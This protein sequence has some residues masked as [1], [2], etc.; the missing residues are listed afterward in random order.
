[1]SEQT[2]ETVTP[3]TLL[4]AVDVRR[5]QNCRLVVISCTRLPET[6]QLTY[7]FDQAGQFG[8]VRLELPV[9]NPVLPSITNLFPAA[10]GY[11]NELHDLFG[12]QIQG[13][14]IDFKGNFYKLSVPTPFAAPAPAKK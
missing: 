11:E 12:L 14:N 10:F 9:A 5:R 8:H 13:I 1:M 3:E 7:S 2:F 4:T 6:F